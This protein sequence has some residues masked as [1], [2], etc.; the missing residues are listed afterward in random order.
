MP[1]YKKALMSTEAL[2]SRNHS[3][4]SKIVLVNL[5][6]PF[7]HIYCYAIAIKSDCLFCDIV[8]SFY[9]SFAFTKIAHGMVNV[10]PIN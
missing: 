5:V 1:A 4:N 8:I 7:K 3:K 9:V 10:F 6:K 2:F